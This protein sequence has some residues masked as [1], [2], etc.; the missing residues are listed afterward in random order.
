M[1]RIIELEQTLKEGDDGRAHDMLDLIGASNNGPVQLKSKR[2]DAPAEPI[3][4]GHLTFVS[5]RVIEGQPDGLVLRYRLRFDDTCIKPGDTDMSWMGDLDYA[6]LVELDPFIKKLT[7]Q[8]ASLRE[9]VKE[10]SAHIR[11]MAENVQEC[12]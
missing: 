10:Q 4:A 12:E 3:Q 5:M 9:L 6:G 2:P 7:E 11:D 1:T 8:V